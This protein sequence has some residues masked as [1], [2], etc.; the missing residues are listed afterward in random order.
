MIELKPRKEGI[1]CALVGTTLLSR[2]A[3]LCSF[4][5]VKVTK[6]LYSLI[7]AGFSVFLLLVQFNVN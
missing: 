7:I 6:V 3:G 5:I 1:T 2:R 4:D